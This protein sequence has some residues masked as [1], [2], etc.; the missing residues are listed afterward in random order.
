[1]SQ[2]VELHF[3]EG[4]SGELVDVCV[5]DEVL[6][7]FEA[8]TR[9]QISLAH[10]ESL[11]LEPRRKVSIRI[12]EL[13]LLKTFRLKAGVSFVTINLVDGALVIKQEESSPG[14]V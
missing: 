1:M 13:D 12:K 9:Y 11:T 5:G 10:I 4:F 3:Q 2:Q 6:T 7:S 8:K 14:Y